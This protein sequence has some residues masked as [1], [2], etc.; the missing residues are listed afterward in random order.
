MCSKRS[1]RSTNAQQQSVVCRI[2]FDYETKTNKLIRPCSCSGSVAYTHTPC[3]EQWVKATGHIK[4]TICGDEF[5]L[6]PLGMRKWWEMSFPRPLSDL[7]E[8]VMDFVCAIAWI[9]YMARFA[10]LG[11]YYG[12]RVMMSALD[13]AMG[14]GTIRMI[15]WIS[16]WFNCLYYGCMTSLIYEKWLMDNTIYTFKDKSSKNFEEMSKMSRKSRISM[17]SPQ[18]K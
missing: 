15:W 9:L 11:V 1:V 18:K 2:C 16:F 4:C 10:Y 14:N 8:D 6:E 17:I 13:E 3:L 12:P 5:V 7:S